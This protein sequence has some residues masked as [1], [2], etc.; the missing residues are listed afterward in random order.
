MKRISQNLSSAAVV[1]GAKRVNRKIDKLYTS[2]Y[3]H[4]KSKESIIKDFKSL[5][6]SGMHDD[7][8]I[9]NSLK[10]AT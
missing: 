6:M 5:P 8:I 7:F 1:I 9:S 4:A 3:P 10:T 2:T